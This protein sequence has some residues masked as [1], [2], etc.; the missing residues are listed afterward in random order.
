MQIGWLV[1]ETLRGEQSL[2][3]G[4]E[5]IDLLL[6]EVCVTWSVVRLLQLWVRFS[7][8]PLF[9]PFLGICKQLWQ[10][11]SISGFFEFLVSPGL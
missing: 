6:F 11:C 10:I 1:G 9:N 8:L 2:G 3:V 7:I 5:L 4:W